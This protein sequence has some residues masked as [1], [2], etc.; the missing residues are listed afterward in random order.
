M[1]M[2][3]LI[4]LCFAM[5]L[6]LSSFADSVIPDEAENILL[7]E[8][9]G[10]N[11]NN[12]PR[13]KGHKAPARRPAMFYLDNYIYLQSPYNI[14]V[15]QIIIRDADDNILYSTIAS[16]NSGVNTIT[17]PLDVADEM[18]SVEFIYNDHDYY[19]YF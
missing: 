18:D 16:I 8:A 14:D 17:L 1:E 13:E 11:D 6:S 9:Y 10:S 19:G 7:V 5:F 2:K 4:I 15:A 3:R 12:V